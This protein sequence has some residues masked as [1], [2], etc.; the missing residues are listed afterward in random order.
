MAGTVQYVNLQQINI[1]Q[2]LTL[3]GKLLSTVPLVVSG[4][5]PT[6]FSTFI[7]RVHCNLLDSVSDPIAFLFQ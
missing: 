7:A 4:G 3:T 6:H 5:L 2:I 1:H